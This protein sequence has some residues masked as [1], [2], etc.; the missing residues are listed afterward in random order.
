MKQKLLEEIYRIHEIIGLPPTKNIE[1]LILEAANPIP[2]IFRGFEKLLDSEAILTAERILPASTERNFEK[3]IATFVADR[4]STDVGKQEIR[5]LIK[6]M[7]ES[8][9]TFAKKFVEKNK[10]ELDK[11]INDKGLDVGKRAIK[12]S[13]G[14]NILNQYEQSLSRGRIPP[15]I[16]PTLPAELKNV[17]GVKEFQDW[18][19]TN[20]PNW[21]RGNNLSPNGKSYGNYGP[22]TTKAWEEHSLEYKRYL[23]GKK[24]ENFGL[25]TG[26][27]IQKFQLWMEETGRWDEAM[28]DKNYQKNYAL[29]RAKKDLNDKEINRFK[30]EYEQMKGLNSPYIVE[31]FGYIEK[32]KEYTM[33]FMDISLHNYIMDNNTKLSFLERKKIVNQIIKAFSYIHSKQLL[34][35]D[36][37]PNNILLKLYDDVIVV[38][39]SDFGLV[40]LP[41]S[42]LTSANTK[43]KGCFNDPNLSF[44][45]FENYEMVHETYALTRLLYFVMTGKKRTDKV[46][47]SNLKDFICKGLNSNKD[48]RFKHIDELSQAFQGVTTDQS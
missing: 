7:A 14:D 46:K 18:M 22:S 37:S 13:F 33:E 4:I 41:E 30:R 20:H 21:V 34:H 40:K 9:P 31:V 38:K 11:L 43:L 32:K 24:I 39:I 45:G 48:Q 15:E 26:D 16:T 29:K 8:S 27:D 6:K 3:R 17:K 47:N 42:N 44:E 35:R 1:S 36:I 28:V 23:I 19:N 12:M 10:T 25:N 2:K 5:N